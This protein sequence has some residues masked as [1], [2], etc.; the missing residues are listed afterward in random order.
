MFQ[1]NLPH[2]GLSLEQTEIRYVSLKKKKQWELEQ[3]KFL[4]IPSGIIVENQIVDTESM[5]HLL[6]KWVAE[7]GLKGQSVTLSIPPSRILVRAM[8]IPSTQAK[9]VSQLVELEVETGLHLPFEN[10]VYDYIV[11]STDEENTHLLVFA[12]P[13]Q[14]IKD[15]I[16][17]LGDA[18]IKVAAVEL[19]ATALA[20]TIVTEHGRSFSN[21][22]LIHLTDHLLD[23]YM[24]RSGQPVFMR[25]IESN[26]GLEDISVLDDLNTSLSR[27]QIDDIIPEIS[28]ML[29]FYQYSLHDGSVKIEE[30]F[31]T[32]L[33]QER[34]LLAHE[35]SQSLSDIQVEA[36]E[37]ETTTLAFQTDPDLNSYRVAVGAALRKEDTKPINLLPQEKREKQQFSYSTIGL[38]ALWVLAMCGSI[39]YMIY[40]NG[41]ITEQQ[42]AIQ[43]WSDRNTLA[44]LELSKWNGNGSSG[45]ANQSVVDA[46]MNYRIDVVSILDSLTKQLPKSGMI[47]DISYNRSSNLLVT[48]SMRN[49][50]DAAN[51]LVQLRSMP[52]VQNATVNKATK[53]SSVAS[54]VQP[55]K[56]QAS[57]YLVIYTIDLKQ[58]SVTGDTYAP[59]ST[60][61]SSQEGGVSNGT[62]Q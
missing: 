35:L 37:L 51:Y 57:L 29:N 50:S 41:T 33:P 28:R 43:Q 44:Q 55:T 19:S 59:S 42:R 45:A 16:S 27:Q 54:A 52:F 40:Q 12:A 34:E 10:P 4:P 48:A 53:D 62:A 46:V 15:Y 60:V 22:M 7:E 11:T 32:G 47:R 38:I 31:V 56:G 8:S 61:I 18:G 17:L 1:R 9:Q 20:R 39:F 14:L 23:I 49:F 24:F 36:V 2:V 5:N 13:S 21:T 30:I 25:S 6:R 26:R 58:P 3:K